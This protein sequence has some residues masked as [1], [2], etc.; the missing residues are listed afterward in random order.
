[1]QT[2]HRH[3]DT[4]AARDLARV[5]RAVA[6]GY[7]LSREG[8][9]C[10]TPL[11]HA[12]LC[13][14]NPRA[15]LRA[16]RALLAAGAEVDPEPDGNGPLFAAVIQQDATVMQVLLDHGAA[17]DREHDMG[18]PILDWAE[19]D[20]RAETYG[21]DMELPERPTVADRA[22]MDTWL[23]FLDR[24]AVKYGKRRPDYLLILRNH[25]ARTYAEMH[26]ERA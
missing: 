23:A 9:H 10:D 17:A 14:G 26:P 4:Q 16:V 6:A 20:Y 22:T 1:M 24:I 2:Q 8:H 7:D 21:E 15:R 19:F 5:R 25:G 3:D 12:I 13:I 18:E 11:R